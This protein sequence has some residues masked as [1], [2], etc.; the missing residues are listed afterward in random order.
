MPVFTAFTRRFLFSC[1]A[2]TGLLLGAA[3]CRSAQS[4]YQFRPAP[5]VAAASQRP[6]PAQALPAAAPA[7]AAVKALP[8][9]VARPVASHAARRP[10]RRTAGAVPAR[11]ARSFSAAAQP[12]YAA[13]VRPGRRGATD[14]AQAVAE[15]G[16]GT[17]VLGVLGL[18]VG[19]ISLVGLLIWGGPVWAVLLGLSALAVLVAYIDP[20]R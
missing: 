11:L 7:S 9:A 12:T 4:A 17:T 18:I 20:F 15:V 6:A 14:G 19:P 1:S 13:V 2:A 3:G 10:V 5:T 16:L 8:A